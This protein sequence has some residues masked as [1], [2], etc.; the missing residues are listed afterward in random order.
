MYA[1]MGV[2]LANDVMARFVL[3]RH[4]LPT[5][6]GYKT[7]AGSLLAADKNSRTILVQWI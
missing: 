5:P 7:D 1:T 2:A 3:L 6:Q 4:K